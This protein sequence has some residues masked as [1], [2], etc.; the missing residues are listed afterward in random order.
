[1][2]NAVLDTN[3]LVSGLLTTHGNPAQIINLFKEK[4]FN[5]FYCY[6]IIDEYRDVLFREKLGLNENDVNNLLDII[7]L[8]GF[9]VTPDSIDIILPDEDDRIF[10][11]TAMT[12]GAYLVTGNIKHFPDEA[13][14]LTPAE[15]LEIIKMN[16]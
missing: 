7:M 12:A 15:F 4:Q 1:M 16:R 14:I 5:L 11:N 3:V 9:P 13:M 6:E 10:Y 8:S 2:I